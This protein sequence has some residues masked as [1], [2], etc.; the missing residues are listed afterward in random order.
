MSLRTAASTASSC[1]CP[2]APNVSLPRICLPSARSGLIDW[3]PPRTPSRAVY[4][5]RLQMRTPSIHAEAGALSGGNQ[6]K[7][8]RW[9]AGSRPNRMYSLL[10]EAH[11]GCRR[12]P[13]SEIPS[14]IVDLA[15]AGAGDHHDLLRYARNPRHERPH[16]RDALRQNRR[17]FSA[18]EARNPTTSYCARARPRR[19]A[20]SPFTERPSGVGLPACA[21][22]GASSPVDSPS[23]RPS[24]PSRRVGARRARLLY[25][26]QPARS[27]AVECTRRS[28]SSPA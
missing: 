24:Q 25:P 16:R 11:A 22:Q 14:L 27:S 15:E 4:V 2:S 20:K 26:R 17:A 6:Q 28:S 3:R 1:R 7:W 19:G 5:E 21:H 12:R 18:R 23:S 10:D 8:C 13:K 9:R